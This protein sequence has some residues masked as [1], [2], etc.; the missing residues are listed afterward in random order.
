MNFQEAFALMQKGEYLSRA[1]WDAE[2]QNSGFVCIMPEMLN[3]WKIIQ[4]PTPNAGVFMCTIA[5][6][7]AED[8]FVRDR[9]H[10]PPA[11]VP[12]AS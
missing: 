4:K 2:G 9:N 6:L 1:G 12:L 3:I 8:W 11:P 10:V 5:D 7:L